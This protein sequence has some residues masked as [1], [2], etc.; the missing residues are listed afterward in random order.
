M[1]ENPPQDPTFRYDAELAPGYFVI[2]ATVFLRAPGVSPLAKVLYLVLCSY[3]GAGDT[4]WPGQERLCR[5]CAV[6]SLTTLHKAQKELEALGLL[7]VQR[8][9]LNLTNLYTLHKLPVLD[10]QNMRV[11]NHSW[12]QSRI[13]PAVGKIDSANLESEKR[14][15]PLI[16]G[17]KTPEEYNAEYRRRVLG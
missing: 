10:S 3:A 5:E 14:V 9:G 2:A 16:Q 17:R 8:R 7:D 1:P 12:R 4:A 11:K 15:P 6:A 13:A